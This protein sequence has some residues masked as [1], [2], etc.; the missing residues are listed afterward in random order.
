MEGKKGFGASSCRQ[1]NI[2]GVHFLRNSA[3]WRAKRQEVFFLRLSSLLTFAA[4]DRS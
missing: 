2:F 4:F 3:A 1:L